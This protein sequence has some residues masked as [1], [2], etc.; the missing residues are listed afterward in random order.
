MRADIATRIAKTT[1]ESLLEAGRTNADLVR[2]V[3]ALERQRQ[4]M[5]DDAAHA[6]GDGIKNG[7]VLWRESLE[8]I[9]RIGRGT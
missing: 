1:A 6:I 7:A 5:M 2:R 4:Q 3:A 8:R 9:V